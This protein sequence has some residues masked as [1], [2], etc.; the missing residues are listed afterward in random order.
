MIEH[1]EVEP[2]YVRVLFRN[3]AHH[4]Q[5]LETDF[6]RVKQMSKS[7]KQIFLMIKQIVP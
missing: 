6:G 3:I 4:F 2:P 1:V 5:D 7:V